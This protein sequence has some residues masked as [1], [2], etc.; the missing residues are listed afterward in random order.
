MG[1]SFASVL[2]AVEAMGRALGCRSRP[3]DEVAR[4]F[5]LT[6]SSP[7]GQDPMN[8]ETPKLSTRSPPRDCPGVPEARDRQGAQVDQLASPNFF[9]T[10]LDSCW[11]R[12]IWVPCSGAQWSASAR[13]AAMATTEPWASVEDAAKHLGVAKDSLYWWSDARKLPAQRIGRLWKFKL[14]EIDEWV[15]AG[16]AQEDGGGGQPSKRQCGR[17]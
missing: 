12:P 8:L 16:G 2:S 7:V 17:R 9:S 10:P 5:C 3:R 15:R 1:R 4:T 14:S 13:S 6:G 11:E